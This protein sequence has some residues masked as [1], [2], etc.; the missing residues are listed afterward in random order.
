MKH[1]IRLI[2]I[3]AALAV[4][5]TAVLAAQQV[6]S[7]KPAVKYTEVKYSADSSSYRWEGDD[8]VLALAGNVKF[9]Q[10]DTILTA[11]KVDYR[12]STK[13]AAAAGNLTIRDDQHT[14]TGDACTMSFKDKK[15]SITGNVRL[16]IKPKVASGGSKLKSD[17][18]DETVVTCDAI[19]YLYKEKKAVISSPLKISQKNRLVTAD[20][21]IYQATDEIVHLSGNVRGSD[22]KDRHTFS[23]PAVTI[24]LKE[25]DEWIEAQKATGSIYIKDE[26]EPKTENK[27]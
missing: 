13:M 19:D 17:L 1:S 4:M 25:N 15:G 16:V 26:D 8:R 2:V 10:G 12:E 9:M 24:S 21:A 11:N 20:S 22:D 6:V 23:A 3:F 27:P 18:K 14:I 7:S 5:V